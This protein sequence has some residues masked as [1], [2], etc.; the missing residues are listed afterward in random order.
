MLRLL[1]GCSGRLGDLFHCS[2]NVPPLFHGLRGGWNRVNDIRQLDLTATCSSTIYTWR[3]LLHSTCACSSN[4]KIDGTVEQIPPMCIPHL[5]LELF[6]PQPFWWNTVEQEEQTIRTP[7]TD[8][9]PWC[10]LVGAPLPP[11]IPGPRRAVY[12]THC[13]YSQDWCEPSSTPT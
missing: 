13:R 12:S 10:A 9:R 1:R 4:E 6:L 3:F 7:S 2:T 11:E 5:P 8:L